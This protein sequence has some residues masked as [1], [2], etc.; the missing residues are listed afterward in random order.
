MVLVV[1]GARKFFERAYRKLKGEKLREAAH[2]HSDVVMKVT[3]Q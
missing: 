1:G 3:E 2:V